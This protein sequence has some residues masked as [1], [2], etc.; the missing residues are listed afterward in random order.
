[1]ATLKKVP[2]SKAQGETAAAHAKAP[3]TIVRR[4]VGAGAP[5]TEKPEVQP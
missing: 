3:K 4:V 1:M 5:A 2:R